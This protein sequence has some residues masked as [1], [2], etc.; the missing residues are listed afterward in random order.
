MTGPYLDRFQLEKLPSQVHREVVDDEPAGHCCKEVKIRSGAAEQ[1]ALSLESILRK[2]ACGGVGI[3][4][5][6]GS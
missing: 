5:V 3:K 1:T 6:I 4:Y 2:D